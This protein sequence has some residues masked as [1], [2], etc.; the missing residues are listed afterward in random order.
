MEKRFP[1]FLILMP[2][3]VLAQS[4]RRDENYPPPDFLKR[5]ITM[6]D[7]CV[8]KTGVSED[9]IKE[10]SDG[11]IVE[12]DEL[13]CY[14]HCIFQEMHVVDDNDEMDYNKLKSHLPAEMEDFVVNILNVCESHVPQGANQCERSWSWH[15]C[16]KTTD[17]VHY[18]LP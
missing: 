4:P 10:F 6:H 11:E 12:N 1:I 5:F 8:G 7:V 18:F 16:F 9:A 14:M 2:L 15:M 3:L 13:K 17:P